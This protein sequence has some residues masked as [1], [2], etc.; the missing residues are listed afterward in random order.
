MS[1]TLPDPGPLNLEFERPADRAH[2]ERTAAEL[3]SRGFKA[4]VADNA[5]QARRLVLD[6]IPDGAEV[7]IALSETMRELGIT[8]EIDESGRYDSLRSRLNKL[9]RATQGREMRKLGA[10]PDY[11][12]GSAHA[13]TDDGQIVVGSG[14]GS[15]LGAYAYA[16]GNVILVVGHQKLV[17]DLDEGLRR[18]REYSLPREYA[19][20]QQ[21]GYPGSLLAKTLIIHHEPSDRITV[22]LVPETL[23]F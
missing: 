16:G 23:G 8:G 5:E 7:H 11:I 21:A 18:V 19:R 3:N 12:V 9:D 22:I 10:A 15:Q 20:M 6:A 13:V 1:I 2:L 4:Q 14:S 17:H